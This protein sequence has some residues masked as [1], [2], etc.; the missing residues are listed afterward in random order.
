VIKEFAVEPEAL[1][2]WESFRYIVEKFGIDQGRVI[3]Q[4]PKK[5]TSKVMAAMTEPSFRNQGRMT[6]RL[7]E[8]QRKGSTVLISFGRPFEPGDS[9]RNNV[10]RE[11]QGRPFEAVISKEKWSDFAVAIPAD[12]ADEK[13]FKPVREAAITRTAEALSAA[14]APLLQCSREY[15]LVDP[16]FRPRDLR[17]RRP[18]EM[19]VREAIARD[20]AVT[21]LEI[22]T[23]FKKD[24][25]TF[26]NF[27][28][29]CEKGL[30]AIVP[31]GLVLKIFRWCELGS[32]GG[33]EGERLHARYLLTERGGIRSEGGWDEGDPGQTTDLSLLTNDLWKRRWEQYRGGSSAFAPADI[34]QAGK[35][36]VV[37]V[38]GEARE[39]WYS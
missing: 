32:D 39:C 7:S 17:C 33:S 16:Y 20:A 11:H 21:R 23:K 5:W 36:Q 30:P 29:A 34:D 26:N 2:T 25:D 1:G 24:D 4:F 3:S 13:V 31:K 8:L 19:M 28:S 15:V 9:W 22:H 10:V 14:C 18:I 12:E 27:N 6:E 37:I 38:V 35:H